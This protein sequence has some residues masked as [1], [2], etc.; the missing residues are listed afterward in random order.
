[1]TKKDA[2]WQQEKQARQNAEKAAQTMQAERD[3]H[4]AARRKA[5]ARIAELERKLG[6]E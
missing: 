4:L 5:E 3:R 1:M 2:A 6:G